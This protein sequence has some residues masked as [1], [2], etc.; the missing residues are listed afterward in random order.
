[1]Q[2]FNPRP[3]EG[4]D[5]H[6]QPAHRR[7]LQF[8]STLPRRERHPDKIQSNDNR[9]FQSTL[10][11]RER[12]G[13]TI[14]QPKRLEFQ[15][16]LPRRE[17]PQTVSAEINNNAIS[18]HAPAKGATGRW[19]GRLVQVQF[20]STLPRRE[21]L[22]HALTI[23]VTGVISIHAP[24]KGATPCTERGISCIPHFNPRSREGSD[25]LTI[26]H[27]P[28]SAGD[29]FRLHQLG[30]TQFLE[31]ADRAAFLR[32]YLRRA[33]APQIVV[34]FGK[35]VAHTLTQFVCKFDRRPSA[36][37]TVE[38]RTVGNLTA[39][40]FLK[41]HRLSAQLQLVRAVRLGLAALVFDWKR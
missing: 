20:Q 35:A 28:M 22:Q 7:C 31:R 5:R 21:R 38:Q 8:Q 1:M 6:A 29:R 27:A 10:P 36:W 17:R 18:I 33:A 15:S 4:S 11:R 14:P 16:T 34:H 41:T 37:L 23:P 39:Q 19:A 13:S 32:F 24:A 12:Q 30:Q 9:K 3:R 40:H 26:A 25:R 2:Y